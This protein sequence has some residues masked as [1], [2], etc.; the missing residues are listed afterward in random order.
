MKRQH[1]LLAGLVALSLVAAA[2]GGDDDDTETG[3]GGDGEELTLGAPPDCEENAFCIPGLADVYGI[4]FADTFVP[5]EL[6]LV[7][8]SLEQGAIDVG[9]FLSTSGQLTDDQFLVLE[10]DEGM[11]A[12]DNVFPVGSQALQDEYGDDL[13]AVLDSVSGALTTEGLVEMNQRYEVDHDDAADIAADWLA[14]ND[15]AGS[16]D[17][18]PVEGTAIKIGAQ[19]F[20]ESAILAE[21]YKQALVGEGF[22]ASTVEVGG[23]RDLLFSAFESGDVNLAPDYVASELNFLEEG[24]ATSDV[25]ESLDALTPLLEA[26]SLVAYETSEAV[27][28]NTFVMLTDRADDLGISS[29]SDLA[30]TMNG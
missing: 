5:L 27:D 12:A 29:L 2:C 8:T 16:S 22:D 28:T 20:G 24:A 3:G 17:A 13:A 21:I 23:F 30:N 19:D 11:L 25:D 7:P 6:D 14:D 26:K 10:D 4:D 9:V 1:T 18:T 15:L